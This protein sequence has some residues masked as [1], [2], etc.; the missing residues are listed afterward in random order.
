M[1]PTISSG[2]TVCYFESDEFK[3]EDIIIFEYPDA[4]DRLMIKRIIGLPGETIEIIDGVVYIDGKELQEEYLKEEP[5]GNYGPYQVPEDSYFVLGD[6][7]NNSNDTRFWTDKFVDSYE[8]H[9]IVI[10]D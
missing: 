7:R 10:V 3:R 8:I 9:G 4:E 1:E 6:N 5:M 2:D